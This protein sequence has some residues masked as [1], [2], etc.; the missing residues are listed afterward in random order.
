MDT[1]VHGIRYELN[2][3]YEHL[4]DL[5]VIHQGYGKNTSDDAMWAVRKYFSYFEKHGHEM[6]SKLYVFK[7]I[8]KRQCV[9]NRHHIDSFRVILV[10]IRKSFLERQQNTVA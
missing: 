5:F 3:H 10:N 7:R 2:S 6:L 4:V 1:T 8:A 9:V